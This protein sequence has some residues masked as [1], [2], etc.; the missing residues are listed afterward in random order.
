MNNSKREEEKKKK[1]GV[2]DCC[3]AGGCTAYWEISK[4]A[5]LALSSVVIADCQRSSAHQISAAVPT[6]PELRTSGAMK[7]GVPTT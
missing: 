5:C 1:L 2:V 4:R 3:R 7:D 6:G